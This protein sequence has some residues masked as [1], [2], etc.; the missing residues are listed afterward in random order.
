MK[1]LANNSPAIVVANELKEVGEIT[2][3]KSAFDQR[4]PSRPLRFRSGGM[5]RPPHVA[6]EHGTPSRTRIEP[7]LSAGPPAR[8]RDFFG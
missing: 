5:V 2:S 4:K 8:L 7:S 6:P 3:K 1:G